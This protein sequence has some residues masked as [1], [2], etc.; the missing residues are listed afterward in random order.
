MHSKEI[1]QSNL[2]VLCF[3]VGSLTFVALSFYILGPGT[4]SLFRWLGI[5]FFGFCAFMFAIL[6]F[7]PQ[8]LLLDHSG[9]EIVGGFVPRRKEYWVNVSDFFVY[10]LPRGGKQIGY[11]YVPGFSKNSSWPAFNRSWRALNRRSFGAEAAIP[12]IWSLKPEL[13]VQELNEFRAGSIE[14]SKAASD[15]HEA[16]RS[17]I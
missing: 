5:G 6:I 11:N 14:E 2:K 10:R 16:D 13:V 9:F 7:R 8:R 17:T 12:N 3:L 1:R 4:S 15:V